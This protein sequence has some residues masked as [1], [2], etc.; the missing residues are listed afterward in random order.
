MSRKYGYRLRTEQDKLQVPQGHHLCV[1]CIILGQGRNLEDPLSLL[2]GGR[3]S[4]ST[5]NLHFL[6]VRKEAIS[7][8]RLAENSISNNFLCRN[9]ARQKPDDG[10][11]Q[12]ICL[13]MKCKDV[14]ILFL[15]GRNWCVALLVHHT[16]CCDPGP[17]Y[18][19][20]EE[21]PTHDAF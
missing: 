2:G 12:F 13:C 9:I 11:N 21:F 4:P 15:S 19:V 18:I 7:L 16:F 10:F 6:P 8:T 20:P 3:N 1:D 14:E 17:C 5:K